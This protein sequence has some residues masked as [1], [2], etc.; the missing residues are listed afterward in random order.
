M[1]KEVISHSPFETKEIGRKFARKIL[2]EKK[3]KGAKI[4]SLEGELGGGKTT[5]LKGFAQTLEIKEMIKSPSFVI[6]K[7][8]KLPT[9]KKSSYKYFYHIDC[10]RIKKPKEILSIGWK[11]EISDSRNII[12][13]EWGDKIKDLLPKDYK[14]IRFLYL[15][16]NKRKIKIWQ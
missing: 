16:E 4:I 1:K 15:C 2:R 7:K 6:M 8:Y 13:V 14:K 9:I 12:V 5:F 10:F 11:K 3:T